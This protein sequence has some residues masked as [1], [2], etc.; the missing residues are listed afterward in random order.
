MGMVKV[1]DLL[2]KSESTLRLSFGVRAQTEMVIWYVIG[3]S[4][5]KVSGPKIS[6]FL[7]LPNSDSGRRKHEKM[8]QFYNGMETLL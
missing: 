5:L 8:L 4:V 1:T 2:N 3:M 7:T 6:I